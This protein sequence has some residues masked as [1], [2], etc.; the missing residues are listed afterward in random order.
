MGARDRTT[1]Q[2]RAWLSTNHIGMLEEVGGVD[3]GPIALDWCATDDAI[4][5]W[6]QD[7][8]APVDE[9]DHDDHG[10]WAYR[11]WHVLPKQRRRGTSQPPT[12]EPPER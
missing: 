3:I 1:P 4:R 6:Q 10:S 9:W 5:R 2:L 12:G 11:S 7:P 8:P